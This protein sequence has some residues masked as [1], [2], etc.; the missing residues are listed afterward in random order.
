MIRGKTVRRGSRPSK[1]RRASD[2]VK[3]AALA[4]VAAGAGRAGRAVAAGAA[5][6]GRAVAAEAAQAA[7]EWAVQAAEEW[8]VLGLVT[9]GKAGLVLEALRSRNLG[10]DAGGRRGEAW[11]LVCSTI[12]TL[13]LVRRARFSQNMALPIAKPGIDKRCRCGRHEYPRH[14][15]PRQPPVA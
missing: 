13:I 4:A 3:A 5:R 9:S 11:R 12:A 8:A 14:K 15:T 10:W 1:G 6:A 2:L 7:E